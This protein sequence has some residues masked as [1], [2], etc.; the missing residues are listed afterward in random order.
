MAEIGRDIGKAAVMLA[1]GKVVAIPTETV[2]GLAGNAYD[3]HAVTR[4][5]EVKNRPQFNP[6]IVHTDRMEKISNF[7]SD[8]PEIAIRLAE[9]FWPGPLTILLHRN[10]IIPD[11][12][13]AGSERVAVRIPNHPVA[14][15]LFSLLEFPVAAPSANPFGYISPTTAQHV[16]EQLGDQISYILD[17]GPAHVGIE[18]TIVGFD[19]TGR[20]EIY[21]FGGTSIE[22]IER[23]CGPVT[24]HLHNDESP[25]SPGMLK[26]HYS[27]ITPMI[28]GD[29]KKL[30]PAF[31]P[32]TTGILAFRDLYPGIP[33]ANQ[34]VLSPDGDI[35][36]AAHELFAAMRSLDQE[37]LKVILAEPVPNY[38]LGRAINDR[39]KRAEQD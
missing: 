1:S 15:K 32:Q 3:I 7:V 2:Y 30:I 4:I 21:R 9:K 17:G 28:V 36:E 8:L 26:S 35:K 6:L 33:A 11:L 14:L 22:E 12:V 19:D 38:G 10:E 5:F 37:K 25:Q 23:V 13:T 16:Q 20:P 18:S 39:L 27:P 29:I 24:M 34:R 31:N